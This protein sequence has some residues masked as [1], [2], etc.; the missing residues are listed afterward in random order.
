MT[1]THQPSDPKHP[2]NI[3]VALATVQSTR[4]PSF[5]TSDPHLLFRPRPSWPSIQ[6]ST[7]L[8]SHDAMRPSKRVVPRIL[9]LFSWRNACWTLISLSHPLHKLTPTAWMTSGTCHSSALALRMHPTNLL[10]SPPYPSA[11]P[12]TQP[13]TLYPVAQATPPLS[14]PSHSPSQPPALSTPASAASGTHALCKPQ[15]HPSS[16]SHSFGIPP[17]KGRT[18]RCLYK[19]SI[20][21]GP[22]ERTWP[23]TSRM[24]RRNS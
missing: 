11:T 1:L 9:I 7:T 12:K 22:L 5:P 21:T 13:R 18:D 16:P 6:T 23:R 17:Y 3:I 24:R 19:Y 8:F 14:H 15:R 4:L 2:Y 20:R 10:S